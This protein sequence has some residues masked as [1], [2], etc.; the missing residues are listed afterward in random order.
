MPQLKM[1][2]VM[3]N[4]RMYAYECMYDLEWERAR[5]SNALINFQPFS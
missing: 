5:S 2:I 1:E 4:Y 3:A